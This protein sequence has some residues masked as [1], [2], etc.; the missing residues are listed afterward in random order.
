MQ[1]QSPNGEEG[2]PGTVNLVVRY[3]LTPGNAMVFETEAQADQ[4]TPITIAQH[5][6]FNLAGADSGSAK[7]HTVQ[8]FSDQVMK[9]DEKMTP[10]GLAEGVEG[11][12]EDLRE[13][14]VL[15]DVIT[16]FWQHH[17]G[18]Y[19]LPGGEALKPAA[20]LTDPESGRVMDV[21]TTHDFM[22]FYTGAHLDGSLGG[23]G[24]VRYPKYG[25]LC[26]ECQGYSDPSAGFGDILVRPG[27]TQCHH[28]VYAFSQAGDEA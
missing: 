5:S 1:Y 18:C 15:G 9:T 21:S 26:F 24:G 27:Q 14:R 3:L 19:P 25:G 6:Y 2:Y 13:T 20:R 8:I 28:T 17:G 16:D 11:R 22:Q 7:N 4:V 23:K 12:A 10:L